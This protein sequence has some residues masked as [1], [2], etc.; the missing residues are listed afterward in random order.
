MGGVFVGYN[1][2]CMLI[3]SQPIVLGIEGNFDWLSSNTSTLT[4]TP[5]SA[6]G[7]GPGSDTYLFSDNRLY[8]VTG[9]IHVP[10]TAEPRHFWPRGLGL[11]QQG[12]HL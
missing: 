4:G 3:G 11:G 6:L 5:T 7:A 9:L 2:P 8:T 1:G 12:R 10:V